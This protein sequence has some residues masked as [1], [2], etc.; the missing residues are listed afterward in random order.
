MSAADQLGEFFDSAQRIDTQLRRAATM[1]NEGV[2]RTAI[3]IDHAAARAVIAIDT[4]ALSKTIPGGVDGS[5]SLRNAVLLVYSDLTSRQ[6]S[7]SRVVRY[8]GQTL[9]R[10]GVDARELL[11]CLGN[12]GPAA[13][14]F[15][16]D[17]ATAKAWAATTAPLSAVAAD[18]RQAASIAVVVALINLANGGCDACG[19]YVMT[20]PLPLVWTKPSMS[21]VMRVDGTVDGIPFQADY[22]NGIGWQ[23]QLMA[24]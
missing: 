16:D 2:G 15:A 17:L 8:D 11:V 13:A 3:K 20:R 23:V 14:R 1:V 10:S 19:G 21:E 7:L 22:R 18:S 5:P 9:P 12:G 24:C 4:R 6:R